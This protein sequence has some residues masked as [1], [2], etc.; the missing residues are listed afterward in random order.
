M[1]ILA[2]YQQA[3][4]H[5]AASKPSHVALYWR[6]A[7]EHVER[8]E[9]GGAQAN[10]CVCVCVGGTGGSTPELSEEHREGLCEVQCDPWHRESVRHCE[11]KGGPAKPHHRDWF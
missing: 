8:P 3:L 4:S 10:V 9:V 2:A 6:Q 5:P 7:G 11:V 1:H